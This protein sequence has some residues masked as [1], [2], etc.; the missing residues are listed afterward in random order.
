M[1]V[2][3]PDSRRF[4]P[5]SSLRDDLGAW[6]VSWGGGGAPGGRGEEVNLGGGGG[7]G[8]GAGL[9]FDAGEEDE[10]VLL[11]TCPMCGAFISMNELNYVHMNEQEIKEKLRDAML[12]MRFALSLCIQQYNAGRLF[13]FEHHAGASSWGTRMMT[14]MLAREGMYLAKFDF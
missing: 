8:G 9:L 2:A 6:E 7:G 10:P 4:E 11:V 13:L 14:E 1:R 3:E 5:T 12:H